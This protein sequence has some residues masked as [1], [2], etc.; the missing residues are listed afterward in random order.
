MKKATLTIL[1]VILA[2]MCTA[3]SPTWKYIFGRQRFPDGLGLPLSSVPNM[4]G[5]ADTNVLFINKADSGLYWRKKG[6][7]VRIID[8]SIF[9]NPTLQTVTNAGNTTT[10]EIHA[11]SVFGNADYCGLMEDGTVLGNR[12]GL[13]YGSTDISI[14]SLYTAGFGYN[15]YIPDFHPPLSPWGDTLVF[16]LFVNG[17]Q[18]DTKGNLSANLSLITSG[19]YKTKSPVWVKSLLIGDTTQNISADSSY[20]LV[21][22][23]AA[24]S[25]Y[26][27]TKNYGT[28][29]MFYNI[30]GSQTTVSG[31]GSFAFGK[32]QNNTTT[33]TKSTVTIDGNGCGFLGFNSGGT[34]QIPS[35]GIGALILG[36]L[37]RNTYQVA[38]NAGSGVWAYTT[39]SAPLQG[40]KVVSSGLGSHAFGIAQFTGYIEAS[41]NGSF[42]NAFSSTNGTDTTRV[43]ATA[44]ASTILAGAEVGSQAINTSNG[45][46]IFGYLEN[47][48]KMTA[49]GTHGAF[50]MGHTTGSTGLILA[51]ADGS[52][53][54]GEAQSDSVYT[55]GT[56][57]FSWGRNLVNTGAYVT[58]LGKGMRNTLDSM[59]LL[60][61]RSPAIAV[62]GST[63]YV[64]FGTTTPSALIH[65][66]GTN[67]AIRFTHGGGVNTY[68]IQADANTSLNFKHNGNSV[69]QLDYLEKMNVTAPI[70][71]TNTLTSVAGSGN[72][73]VFTTN[74][75]VNTSATYVGTEYT[76]TVATSSSNSSTITG[77]HSTVTLTTSSNMP[78][79]LQGF[80]VDLNVSG[81]GG[82]LNNV[83]GLSVQGLVSNG[84]TVTNAYGVY[85][86]G[87][88]TPSTGVVYNQ[89][90]YYYNELYITPS[91]KGYAFYSVVNPS[92]GTL[93]SATDI[94]IMPGTGKNVGVGTTAPAEKLEINGN[95]RLPSTGQINNGSG[96]AYLAFNGNNV[97]LGTNGANRTIVNVVGDTYP[98][99][100]LSS[101]L[102]VSGQVWK[103]IWV[104]GVNTGYA[105]KAVDYTLTASDNVIEVTA[106]GKTMTLPTAVG[107]YR[108]YVIKLTASGSCTVATTSGQTIDGA[109]NYSLSAQYKYVKVKSNNA[110]WLIIA[111]N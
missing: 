48:S 1:A 44:N 56:G 4:A 43:R 97:I 11:Y 40:A 6:S 30:G 17:K 63:N 27:K 104:G 82:T 66:N 33:S 80:G 29:A 55:S 46:G 92:G 90:G 105:A 81:G 2:F 20:S 103:D 35:T 86:N 106:T 57:S 5:T 39:G 87:L 108:E 78:T 21:G 61:F 8:G 54:G 14:G 91:N 16:P 85:Y 10:N 42:V 15:I 70:I 73:N 7:A 31:Q 37:S 75:T 24:D 62:N 60:G 77:Q 26:I 71:A 28:A 69:M 94:S 45:G 32:G 12:F 83:K 64:G 100:S 41:G 47:N 13:R 79:A 98:N 101:E 49:S 107:N 84:A 59:I 96:A 34:A 93:A 76:S 19:G 67:P 95:L 102:G 18:A 68:D 36:S 25:S 72:G 50:V 109:A 111:N 52:F 74:H 23:Y 88:F 53:A 3:Q 38:N 110:N 99:A 22:G 65:I 89:Y 58:M 9:T 51:G